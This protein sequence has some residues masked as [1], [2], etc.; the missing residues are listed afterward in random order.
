[1][2]TLFSNV[3]SMKSALRQ[4]A[5][6]IRLKSNLRIAAVAIPDQGVGKTTKVAMNSDLC[7]G[8]GAGKLAFGLLVGQPVTQ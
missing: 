1:M 2:K 7:S 6:L 5:S 8:A 3:W 4:S